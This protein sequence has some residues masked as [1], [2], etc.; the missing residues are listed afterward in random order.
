LQGGGALGAYQ[1]GAFRALHA[2]CRQTN[3]AVTWAGGI[4]IGAVNAAVIAAPRGGDPAAE[5]M[6]LWDDILSPPFA[7]FDTTRLWEN[8]PPIVR[9]GWL[10]PL[11]PKYADVLWEALNPLGQRNFFSSRVLDPVRN[12]WIRQWAG[13]VAPGD[14][15]LYDSRRLRETLDKHVDWKA[16]ERAAATRLSLGAARVRNGEIVFF[17]SFQSE[18]TAWVN[19]PLQAAHVLASG[20]LPPGFPPVFVENDWFWDGGVSTNTPIEALAEDLTADA[21]MA[22]IV[23]LIDLWDRSG[24]IPR[25]F[26]EVL[27]RQKSI[28]YGSLNEAA[29]RVVNAHQHDVDTRQVPPSPLEVCQIILERPR[30]NAPPQFSLADADFSRETFEKLNELGHADMSAAI[31]HPRRVPGVGGGDAVLYRHGTYGKHLDTDGK[32]AAQ[33]ERKERRMADYDRSRNIAGVS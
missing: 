28:D 32:Y 12:P 27:W 23:F 29:V 11:I 25:S 13:P 26:D 17:N 18:N 22:T 16:L 9:S 33:R 6:N 31:A 3:A 15:G 24:P 5:L 1:V 4:S 21:S 19:G 20:A 8:T 30:E 14:L 2:I 10:A 7:P